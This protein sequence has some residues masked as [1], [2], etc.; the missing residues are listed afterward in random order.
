MKK[1]LRVRN[2]GRAVSISAESLISQ[3]LNEKVSIETIERLLVMR[4]ELKQEKAKEAYNLA[5]AHFQSECPIIKKTKQVKN[6]DGSLRY[7]YAPLDSI[8]R[9]TKGLIQKHGF[10][11]TIDAIVEDRWVSAICKIVH[12]LGHSESSHFRIPIISEGFMTEPQKFASALT[13]AKR[14]AFCN[15]F[16]IL[17][18][19]ED[20]DSVITAKPQVKKESK[21]RIYQLAIKGIEKENDIIVLQEILPQLRKSKLYT[22]EQK[23]NLIKL[24]NAK[25]KKTID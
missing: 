8:V 19:D 24:I 12:E 3:A 9:Q 23:N 5:M 7:G 10:S 16:G 17:T 13:F 1:I 6:K 4:R 15:A 25:I 18:G 20:D 11:Y 22:E 2:V 21:E 14:Y